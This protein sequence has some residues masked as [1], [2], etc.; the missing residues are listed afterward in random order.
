MRGDRAELAVAADLVRRGHTV[1]FPFGEDSDYDLIVDRGGLLERVQVKYAESDGSRLE[2][3]CRSHSLTN[4]KVRRTKHYTAETIDWLAVYDSSTAR[5]FY[6]PAVELGMGR[7][8]ITLRLRPALN[9]QR[10]GVRP[11]ENYEVIGGC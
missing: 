3:R 11:A 9:N 2:V 5:C 8:T 10:S 4:G 6:I 1:A 7:S